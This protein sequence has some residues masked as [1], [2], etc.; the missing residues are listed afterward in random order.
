[1]KTVLKRKTWLFLC[2]IV[3]VPIQV[4]VA[5]PT[6]WIDLGRAKVSFDLP[7]SWKTFEKVMGL[8]LLIA[9]PMKNGTRITVSITPSDIKDFG[10][11][12]TDFSR[13]ENAYKEDAIK[14]LSSKKGEAKEFFPYKKEEWSKETV[15]HVFG[16]KYDLGGITFVENS[17][18]VLCNKQLFHIK[19][20]YKEDFDKKDAPKIKQMLKTFRCQPGANL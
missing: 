4:L 1:M 11:K 5:K 16:W 14:W 20:M 2:L 3:I 10:F 12:D 6:G 7:K 15:A 18:Y 19:S 9:S 8:R 13:N 17:M